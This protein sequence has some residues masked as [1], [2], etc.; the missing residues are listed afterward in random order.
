MSE[1]NTQWNLISRPE[2]EAR[3]EHF[4]VVQRPK[5]VP[6]PGEIL[7]RNIYLF[8]PP[9]MRL[10]MN[11]KESYFPPQPL[12][13]PMMGITLGI[14]EKSTVAD[15][16]AGTYVNGMGGW[17]QWYLASADQLQAVHPHP[18]VPLA[19]YRTVLEAQGLT[20]YCGLTEIGQPKPGDTLVVTSAAGSVGSLVCQ[21]GRKLGLRVVGIAGGAE[22]CRWLLD[23]CGVAGAIDYRAEDVGARLDALCPQGIDVVFENVGGPVMDLILDRI[24]TGA[25]I[26]L[27]GLIASYNAA[28]VQSTRSLMQ[29]VNKSARMEGFL[30]LNFL[31]RGP[32]VIA[33]LQ[34]W[35]LDGSLQYQMEILDGLDRV[36]EAMSRVFHGQNHGVQLVRISPEQ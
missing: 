11:E 7:V 10:W 33:K 9:S 32:E 29:L 35:I 24:N 5:P 30:V 28:T 23:Y 25:R 26:A 1:T 14:V 20:A 3:R 16:P 2:G 8:V 12:G 31:H 19:A 22:K 15:L 34:D 18:R 4:E 6:G 13:Q 27:S 36:L 21:I 17:Q